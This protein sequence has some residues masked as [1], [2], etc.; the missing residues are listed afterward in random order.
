M[1][2]TNIMRMQHFLVEQDTI[3]TEREDQGFFNKKKKQNE[4]KKE[5]RR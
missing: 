4:R 1:M 3:E 2:I 5:K